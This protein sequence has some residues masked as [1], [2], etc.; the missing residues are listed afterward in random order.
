MTRVLKLLVVL[1]LLIGV[2]GVY[3][4]LTTPTH[5]YRFSGDFKD[6]PSRPSCVS[7]V[8]TD[9]VHAIAPLTYRG[10]AEAVADQ[11]EALIS[12]DPQGTVAYRETGYLHSVYVSPT[13]RYHD[14][15]ELLIQPDGLIQVRSI[16]RFGYRDFDV[17]RNRVE[18]LRQALA[19]AAA[20]DPASP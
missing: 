14:D 9:P 19:A 12:A 8:A 18:A 15:L 3:F 20:P 10:E 1:A 4:T 6:C 11:L 2:T 16:S 13:M 7:S 5:L 17:N